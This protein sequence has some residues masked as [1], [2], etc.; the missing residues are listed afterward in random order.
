[1]TL[2]MSKHPPLQQS[3][4]ASATSVGRH[5]ESLALEQLLQSGLTLIERNYRCRG[6]EIDLIMRDDATLVFIEV[7]FRG[8][9]RYGDG[10]AQVTYGKQQK[11]RH[12]ALTYLSRQPAL[13]QC[14]CRFDVVGI[15]RAGGPRALNWIKNAF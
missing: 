7:K 11:L 4:R 1:M 14:A 3:D 5:Y 13:S 6:G 10:I 15:D 12:A 9:S 8:H 2:R